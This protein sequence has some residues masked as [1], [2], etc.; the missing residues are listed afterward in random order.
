MKQDKLENYMKFKYPI[1][2]TYIDDD[3]GGGVMATIPF[4]GKYA[5]VGDGET[6]QEALENL[7]EIKKDLFAEYLKKGIEIPLPPKEEEYSGKFVI[8]MPAYLHQELVEQANA[9]GVSLN[10]YCISLIGQRNIAQCIKD[11]ISALAH[12]IQTLKYAFDI[13]HE[14]DVLLDNG[15]GGPV[16]YFKK[17]EYGQAS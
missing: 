10:T 6:V 3:E 14:A 2:I 13:Y 17:V 5:F 8:R 7:E 9:N 11:Q 16:R 4:L 1:E 15:G 12:N